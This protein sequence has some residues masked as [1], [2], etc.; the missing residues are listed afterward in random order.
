MK[1]IFIGAILT[2]LLVTICGCGSTEQVT[3]SDPICLSNTLNEQAML[4]ARKVLEK[5]HFDIEKFDP[6]ARYM[7]TR[8]L[9]GA[10]FFEF[11]R[12]DNASAYTHSQAN[13]HSLR[14]TVEM[15]FSLQN[16][17]T[18]IQCC[19]QVYR[20]SLPE[21]P[22]VGNR[23]MAGIYTASSYREQTLDV[24]YEELSQVEWLYEGQDPALEQKILELI[25]KEIQ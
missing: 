6:E 23:Q 18:C 22:I 9:S 15:E 11:W 12:K 14:R 4:T 7:R 1:N 20:L 19:V 21:R 2:G 10:Q 25:R 5:M 24:G 13:L 17:S 8:P 3:A 16:T